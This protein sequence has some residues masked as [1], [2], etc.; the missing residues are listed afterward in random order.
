MV[1]CSHVLFGQFSGLDREFCYSVIL[2]EYLGVKTEDGWISEGN[3]A[4]VSDGDSCSC[5]SISN[6]EDEYPATNMLSDGFFL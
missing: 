6:L 2:L 4:R 5:Y 1:R 3:R